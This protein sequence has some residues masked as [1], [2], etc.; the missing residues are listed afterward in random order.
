MEDEMEMEVLQIELSQEDMEEIEEQARVEAQRKQ[1]ILSTLAQE[2][3]GKFTERD[4]RLQM[5]KREWLEA[6]RLYLGSLSSDKYNTSKE[7][8]LS[9]DERV[10]R[11]YH[12]LVRTKC[13]VAIAQ[14]VMS[15]FAGGDKNW[16][17]T[18]PPD[19]PQDDP[20]LLTKV[21]NM[22]SKVYNQQVKENYGYKMRLAMQDR[23]ILGTGIVKGP[24][25][26]TESSLSYQVIPDPVTG[27]VQTI[28]VYEVKK[29]PVVTNVSPWFFFPDDTVN[30]IRDAQDAIELHP[31]S[32]LQV[33][34]LAQNPGFFPEAIQ[35]LLQIEPKTYANDTFSE[36]SSLTDA[37]QNFL[38][39]KYAVLEY[40][41]PVSVDQLGALD[42]EPSY[43]P[44]GEMYFGEVWVCQG[45]VIRA[46]LEA[47]SG[48]YELPYSVC[49]WCK[50]PNS[51]FGFGLP[52]E[53]K[54]PQKI[55]QVTLDMILENASISSGPIGIINKSFIEPFDGDWS[56]YPH[57]L[58]GTTDYTLQNV[59]Q[60]MT[61][62]DVP[63][64][65]AE[66]FPILS[67][68]R[69]VA[70]EESGVPL[71]AG[72][73][74][75]ANV[76]SDSATGLAIQ[77]KNE[78]LVSDFKNEEWDDQITERILRRWY[79]FNMQFDPTPD[80]A[81]PIEIDVKSST[82]YRNKQLYVRDIEKLSVESAQNP[83]LG[84]VINQDA[85]QRARLSMMHI[86]SKEIIKS[87]DQV[88]AEQEQAKQNQQPSPEEMKMQAEMAK[89]EVEREKLALEREKLNFELNQQQRREEMDHAERMN[90]TYARHLEAEARVTE[91]MANREVEMLKLAQKEDS[92]KAWIMAELQKS[93]LQNEA[94]KFLAGVEAQ[95]KFREQALKAAELDYAARTGKGI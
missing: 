63:N 28:P 19:Y 67:F 85:L 12:N 41:G 22:E 13:A 54:D 48:L 2:I 14:G 78:T 1:D 91:A 87:P 72:S 84:Q 27:N 65:S 46:E 88:R 21:E 9:S 24:L 92:D 6:T 94:N 17:F 76:Q 43:E 80:T 57:K 51:I 5:K 34:K 11:P 39:D 81:V 7:T 40:H 58:F 3:E 93:Q 26:S 90:A 62:I 69:E 82:E 60:A 83:A 68:A 71:L 53:I 36:Y 32:K 89:L 75:S 31:M 77:Q 42:I 23:V 37:G 61:F 59:Q 4:S 45:V 8:P 74:Q 30:D 20:D 47:I 95:S 18:L 29:R 44:L 70:Q 50:D 25:P 73:L 35:E 10:N 38:R 66:L 16:D 79:H 33:A 86:P 15:Q 49:A 55:A 56:L 52:L 64:R